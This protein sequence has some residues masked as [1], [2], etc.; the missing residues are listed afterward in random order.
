LAAWVATAAT[1]AG[2]AVTVG[3]GDE[4]VV[5]VPVVKSKTN[6]GVDMHLRVPTIR[7]RGHYQW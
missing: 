6:S 3:I 7:A 5:T 1:V 2:L 4:G